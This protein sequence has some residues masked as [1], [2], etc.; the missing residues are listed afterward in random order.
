MKVTA[1]FIDLF[2]LISIFHNYY[3]FNTY[4]N[5]FLK[6]NDYSEPEDI[7]NIQHRFVYSSLFSLFMAH[8]FYSGINILIIYFTYIN[9]NKQIVLSISKL[10]RLLK[11]ISLCTYGQLLSEIFIK[12]GGF[13]PL[14][15]ELIKVYFYIGIVFVLF[16]FLYYF[17]QI[18]MQGEFIYLYYVFPLCVK[19]IS[20]TNP[21]KTKLLV[22]LMINILFMYDLEKRLTVYSN[23]ISLQLKEIEKEIIF[24]EDE[25]IKVEKEKLDEL[26]KW[27]SKSTTK[28]VLLHITHICFD[29]ARQEGLYALIELYL[30]KK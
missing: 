30:I 13:H 24:K 12:T 9:K 16:Q 19:F 10:Y 11:K 17:R 22:F 23:K 3:Q 26:D 8:F 28:T 6:E 20:E 4:S 27:F 25:L 14:K 29:I 15:Y 2:Y 5:L 18:N 21:L 1:K 7:E